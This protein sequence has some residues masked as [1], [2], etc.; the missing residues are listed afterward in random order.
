M[1]KQIEDMLP[2]ELKAYYKYILNLEFSEKPDY[3]GLQKSIR[4]MW[5]R[6]SKD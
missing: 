6:I 4:D 2:M 5:M 3:L 1:V